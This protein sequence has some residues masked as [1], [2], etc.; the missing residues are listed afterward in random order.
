MDEPTRQPDDVTNWGVD[1][2]F[3]AEAARGGPWLWRVGGSGFEGE[4][5]GPVRHAHDDAAEYYYMFQGSAYV[6]TGGEEFVLEEG[7]LGYIPPDAPH[8]FLGPAG[9]R[10]AYFFCVIAPNFADNKWRVKDFRP[11]SES[12]RMAVGS[13]FDS[14]VL[15]GGATLSAEAVHLTADDGVLGVTP[16]GF[17]VVYLVV[18]GSI[19]IRMTGGLHGTINAGTYLHLRDGLDHELRAPTASRILRFDCAFEAW[20]GTPT[21]EDAEVAT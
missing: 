6:E 4:P 16:V 14:K 9:D 17:D 7:E 21:A 8:N 20:R 19:D 2:F 18:Q 3:F 5:L 1:P 11:G 12:L 10:D 15:P 13:P